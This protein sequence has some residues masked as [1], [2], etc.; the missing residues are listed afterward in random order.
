MNQLIQTVRENPLE[1]IS[2]LYLVIV[3]LS[4]IGAVATESYFPV[5]VP[6][7]LLFTSFAIAHTDK[8][9]LLLFALIPLSTE[10][11]VTGG[12]GTDM[13]SEPV[14]WVLF[15]IWLFWLCQ[16]QMVRSSTIY[17]H[18]LTWLISMHLAW[19]FVA[20][21]YSENHIISIKFF[22]AKLWYVG[23]FYFLAFYMLRDKTDFKRIMMAVF[24]SLLFTV[25]VI[26]FR[27]AVEGGLSFATINDVVSP[28]YRN[29]V[30]YSSLIAL[31]LPIL[32]FL[33][34][35][36]KENSRRRWWLRACIVFLL[37]AL[38]F[39]YTRATMIAVVAAVF[40]PF[41]LKNRLIKPILVVAVLGAGSLTYH[42]FSG[43]T[44]L[45]H[46]PEF[47]RTIMHYE[48]DNLLEATYQFEDISTMERFYR[49]IAGYYMVA[50]R[51]LTGFGPNAFYE[52][53]KPYTVRSFQTYVSD[54]PE[55]SG[56][57]N[58]FLMLMIEQGIPGFLF[59][60]A[61]VVVF[62]LRSQQLYHSLKPGSDKNLLTA[63]TASMIV[64]LLLQLMN[65]LIEVDK[66]GTF[67][68][69]WLAMLVKLEM[70]WRR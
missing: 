26:F 13:P 27:H 35:E 62:L 46:A 65:D 2:W 25:V 33:F 34:S 4:V 39:G 14:M 53:Y 38:Y 58:Y 3:F 19:I 15:G 32:W 59:F 42:M 69:L 30:N 61:I 36:S 45:D 55:Q 29:K 16:R 17:R 57:H 54:N 48:F 41:I 22:L 28:F 51:P 18:P 37:I 6:L 31:F 11:Q 5:A 24:A 66:V 12:L 52:N 60:F 47:D 9:F 7:I 63:I 44:F 68:W 1:K 21:I 8:L 64:I 23:V 67:F 50:D 20:F 70:N 49:W 10:F 43:E 40:T 56:I